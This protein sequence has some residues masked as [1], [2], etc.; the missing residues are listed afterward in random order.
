MA[1]ADELHEEAR[2]WTWR[3][4]LIAARLSEL[5]DLELETERALARYVDKHGIDA[6]VLRLREALGRADDLLGTGEL[7]QADTACERA[8]RGLI[9]LRAVAQAFIRR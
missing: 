4:L 9:A 8:E 6:A 7:D 1:F 5:E 2:C 3:R